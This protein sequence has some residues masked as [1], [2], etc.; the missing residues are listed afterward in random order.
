MAEQDVIG[1]E[2]TDDQGH[3]AGPQ[4]GEGVRL[5]KHKR[6]FLAKFSTIHTDKYPHQNLRRDFPLPNFDRNLTVEKARFEPQSAVVIVNSPNHSISNGNSSLPNP[7]LP[8]LSLQTSTDSSH[9]LFLPTPPLPPLL[10]PSSPI[11]QAAGSDIQSIPSPLQG[12]RTK[13]TESEFLQFQQQPQQQQPQQQQQHQQQHQHQQPQQQQ[14]SQQS[15]QPQQQQQQR[16][17]YTAPKKRRRPP[18]PLSGTATPSEVFHRNLVDAVSNVEDSDENERYVYPYSNGN[19]TDT[20]CHYLGDPRSQSLYRTQS[21]R[22]NP[23]PNTEHSL[24]PRLQ[25]TST[26]FLHQLFHKTSNNDWT[27]DEDTYSTTRRD[28]SHHH[29]RPKLRNYVVDHPHHRPKTM[30]SFSQYTKGDSRR[31]SSRRVYSTYTNDGYTS[32]DEGLPLLRPGRPILRKQKSCSRVVGDTIA[33]LIGVLI[34]LIVFGLYHA[35]PLESIAVEMG[36]VLAS[37]KELIFDLHVKANNWNWWTVHVA[38]ADISVFAFSQVVPLQFNTSA[39]PNGVDPAEYLG[40]CDHFDEALAFPSDHFSRLT[41]KAITQIRIK[42]P[43]ADKS[44]NERWSRI[45]RYPYGLVARGVLKYRP[46]P[47]SW[48]YS[49]SIAICDVAR[50]DPTTGKVSE[51]PDQGYCLSYGQVFR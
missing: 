28:S 45:I 6:P 47:F 43:G 42:S 17:S 3:A 27:A 8:P 11:L 23:V 37:D 25:T 12:N 41:A 36:R 24:P 50:V 46:L 1:S 19:T 13:S 5:P 22:S 2:S 40:S 32:D 29:H 10:A 14:Q 44:G 9:D 35:Q 4:P 15:Q 16:P 34:F 18:P 48:A 51:D 20:T 49:Q 26:G 21:V 33:C 31:G 39:H 30:D 7:P 38:E